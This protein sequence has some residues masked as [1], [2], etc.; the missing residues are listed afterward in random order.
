[1]FDVEKKPCNQVGTENQILIKGSALRLDSNEG[2]VGKKQ[3][4][5]QPKFLMNG[6]VHGGL[7][8]DQ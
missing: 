8:Q 4:K 7:L 5:R 3:K 2:P 1:M 6:C